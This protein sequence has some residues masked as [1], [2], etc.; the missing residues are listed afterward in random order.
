MIL[1]LDSKNDLIYALD[2]LQQR[3]ANR[4]AAILPT[5]HGYHIYTNIETSFNRAIWL[6]HHAGADPSWIKI[7]RKRGYFFLAD[8]RKV[9]LPWPLE[10]MILYAKK[11]A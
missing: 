10:R 5:P 4:I 11:E 3:E 1:D 8:K 6:A 7:A 9:V 2:F